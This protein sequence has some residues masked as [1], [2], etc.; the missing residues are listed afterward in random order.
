M[1]KQKEFKQ[2]E[3]LHVWLDFGN[4]EIKVGRLAVKGSK[5]PP[6]IDREP[7]V[8]IANLRLEAFWQLEYLVLPF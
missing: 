6:P 2:V 4:T 1:D 5:R 7:F 3:L 8:K